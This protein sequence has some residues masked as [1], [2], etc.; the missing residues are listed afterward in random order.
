ML[1]LLLA[2]NGFTATLLLWSYVKARFL[3]RR[4]AYLFQLCDTWRAMYEG[5]RQARVA[6]SERMLAERRNALSA[7]SVVHELG[8]NCPDCD[9]MDAEEDE[10]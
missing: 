6:R 5:V 3:K 4:E 1:N 8:C 2:T 7:A 10:Q 9:W